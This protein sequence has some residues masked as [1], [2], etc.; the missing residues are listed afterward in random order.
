MLPASVLVTLC[1]AAPG[2]AQHAPALSD[3]AAREA[4]ET[5]ARR[6]ESAYNAGDS[7]GVAGLFAT[8]G[9]YLAPGG[10]VLTSRQGIERAVASRMRAGWTR[11]AV[12]VFTAHPAGDALWAIGEY[13]TAGS[14]QNS[15]KEVGGYY[16]EVLTREGPDW[17]LSLWIGNLNTPPTGYN[18]P[19]PVPSDYGG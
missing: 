9:V 13:T 12:T 10:A 14:G 4:A 17:R 19:P 11:V 2:F 15:G 3:Q 7:A 16:A 5:A 18:R 8:G 6:F 1:A